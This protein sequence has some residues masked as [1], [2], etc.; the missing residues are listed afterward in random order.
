MSYA[1][2]TIIDGGCFVEKDFGMIFEY[3]SNVSEHGWDDKFSDAEENALAHSCTHVIYVRDCMKKNGVSTR[4]AIVK[5]TVAYVL[6]A[7]ND[8]P[9]KLVKWNI[10]NNKKYNNA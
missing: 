5:K 4:L 3:S 7:E 9:A 1:Q 2:H 6:T 8:E 10:K